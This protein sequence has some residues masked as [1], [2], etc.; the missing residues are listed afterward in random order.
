MDE[1]WPGKARKSKRQSSSG[2]LGRTNGS[3]TTDINLS[4]KLQ[5]EPFF[6]GVPALEEAISPPKEVVIPSEEVDEIVSPLKE[7]HNE[8][9]LCTDCSKT[10]IFEIFQEPVQDPYN[11]Q[12]SWDRVTVENERHCPFCRL[13]LKTIQ[14]SN[15]LVE[16]SAGRIYGRFVRFA[17]DEAAKSYYLKFIVS[18]APLPNDE[19]SLPKIFSYCTIPTA[20]NKTCR[21]HRDGLFRARHLN[22]HQINIDLVSRWLSLCSECHD[23]CKPNAQAAL[24]MHRQVA[25]TWHSVMFGVMLTSF[26]L[27]QIHSMP[28]RKM[29]LCM[30]VFK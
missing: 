24:W 17:R 26:N 11:Q 3:G 27:P 22:P 4:S 28:S 13:L 6:N 14:E 20:G 23:G 19:S 18:L 8:D 1:S 5:T 21:S 10:N 7:L 30:G 29:G 9:R 12:Y 2:T 15:D 25:S 16:A